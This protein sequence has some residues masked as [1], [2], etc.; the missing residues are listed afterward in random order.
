MSNEQK[1]KGVVVKSRNDIYAIIPAEVFDRYLISEKSNDAIEAFYESDVEGQSARFPSNLEKSE[2]GMFV[3][4][5]HK[6]FNYHIV[7]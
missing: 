2:D 5:N 1:A 6:P 7:E 3:D 4:F